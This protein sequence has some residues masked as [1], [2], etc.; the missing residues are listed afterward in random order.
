MSNDTEGTFLAGSYEV[1]HY[2]DDKLI[3]SFVSENL[4]PD[5]G[6]NYILNGVLGSTALVYLATW[7]YNFAYIGLACSDFIPSATDT[8]S[9]LVTNNIEP[10]T[11]VYTSRL[12][13][14]LTTEIYVNSFTK[15]RSTAITSTPI[16]SDATIYGVFLV[17]S[18]GTP[19]ANVVR[20]VSTYKLVS[21]TKFNTPISVVAGDVFT[22]R[23][24]ISISSS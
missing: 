23:Y 17:S 20:S 21:E 6:C 8:L 1:W 18:T 9:T 11:A 13:A 4:I 10:T 22:T 3:G 7:P 19:G 14:F 12:P 5:V 16:L 15:S 2:R 24:T